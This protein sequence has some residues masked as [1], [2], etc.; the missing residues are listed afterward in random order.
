M[1]LN[2]ALLLSLTATCAVHGAALAM[3]QLQ[4]L[5]SL[6]KPVTDTVETVKQI[7]GL[8]GTSTDGGKFGPKWINDVAKRDVPEPVHQAQAKPVDDGDRRRDAPQLESRQSGSRQKLAQM[9]GTY[10]RNTLAQLSDRG[11]CNKN[12]IAVRKEWGNMS[13]KE[14]LDFI[15][16]VKCL[17]SK[18]S[19]TPQ[20]VDRRA[21]N[22]WDDFTVAH[23][24]NTNQIHWSGLMF[25]W[26]RNFLHKLEQEMRD[27]CGYPG[28]LPWHNYMNNQDN[29]ENNPL[30][31]GTDTS[32]GG[33]GGSNGCITNGPFKDYK[34]NIPENATP[35]QCISRAMD[36]SF[37]QQDLNPDALL[38]LQTKP[39]IA[40]YHK[41]FEA[42]NG[43]HVIG[44]GSIGGLQNLILYSS[45]DVYF[46]FHH[47]SVDRLWAIWA[48]QDFKNRANALDQN[49]DFD[50]RHAYNFGPLPE[51]NLDTELKLSPPWGNTKIRDIMSPTGGDL[52]YM[53]D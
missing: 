17:Q 53:Y 42:Q 31:D 5:D 43:P 4:G 25:P 9:H 23:V 47:A 2:K 29:L 1:I 11:K 22:R 41:Q 30:F 33:N 39:D 34:I 36:S 10:R 48:A 3:P 38:D 49:T 15:A 8:P 19:Q 50:E 45:Q 21:K 16:A 40:S 32:I 35:G 18:P 26:H 27:V 24:L 7:A 13:R 6:V 52:C 12:N 37:L 14:R 46:F 51:A 44:H 20:N 28:Y